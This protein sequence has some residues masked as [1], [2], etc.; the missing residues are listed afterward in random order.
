MDGFD[1]LEGV[2]HERL[3]TVELTGTFTPRESG[4]HTFGIKGLGAFKLVVDGT[5]Y[6]DDVQRTDTDDPFVTFF[7]APEPRAQV[8]L[9]AGEPV[10][11]SSPTSS[12]SPR[13]PR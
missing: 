6:Y 13:R 3:H 9:T 8:D 12:S 4:A 7:G 5:T 1:L 11:V 2:T 10:E